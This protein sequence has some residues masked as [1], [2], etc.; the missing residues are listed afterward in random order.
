MK[1]LI[2]L[3]TDAA[4]Q[5]NL[6]NGTIALEAFG[7]VLAS[8]A[9]KQ[10]SQVQQVVSKYDAIVSKV[11]SF[12]KNMIGDYEIKNIRIHPFNIAISAKVDEIFAGPKPEQTYR[13]YVKKIGGI[14]GGSPTVMTLRG[15]IIKKRTR[16]YLLALRI[17]V[18]LLPRM[19]AK[20]DQLISKWTVESDVK[21]KENLDE[22]ASSEVMTIDDIVINVNECYG[23]L[24]EIITKAKPIQ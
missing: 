5:E 1:F 11:Q 21:K 7:V 14:R 22:I 24:N 8:A 20:R 10:D 18:A 19:Q 15:D 16:E 23:I 6:V 17:W 13:A 4:H 3:D 2:N 9:P 12:L